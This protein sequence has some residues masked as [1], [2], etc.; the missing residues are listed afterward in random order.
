MISNVW[1]V[2]IVENASVHASNRMW[3]IML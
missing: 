1:G 2:N 3:L